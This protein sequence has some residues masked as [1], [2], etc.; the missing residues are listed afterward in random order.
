MDLDHIP[1]KPSNTLAS[2]NFELKF[3]KLEEVKVVEEDK[4]ITKI[5]EELDKTRKKRQLKVEEELKELQRQK[6]L[7]EKVK[8]FERLKKDNGYTFDYEGNV[9]LVKTK[10]VPVRKNPPQYNFGAPD[11]TI[12]KLPD[13]KKELYLLIMC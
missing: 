7:Q 9:I 1:E 5:R 12:Q 4:G 6:E 11:K 2:Q 10:H 13:V 3:E 8:N